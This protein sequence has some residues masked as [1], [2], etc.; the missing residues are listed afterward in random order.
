MVLATHLIIGGVLGGVIGDQPT[1]AFTAGVFSHFLLDAIPH[2]D[3][4]LR[5]HQV[6]PDNQLNIS[7]TLNRDFLIDL[8]KISGDL[9]IGV[10]LLWLASLFF[11]WPINSSVLWGVLGGIL[12]DFLQFAYFKLKWPILRQL[13]RF[14]LWIHSRHRLKTWTI[15]GPILQVVMVAI[16]ILAARLF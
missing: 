2:W 6:D 3:Y 4:P 13:Q 16:I 11:G 5:S 14:H 15:L 9:T 10:F 12:P 8:I 1:L 7:M